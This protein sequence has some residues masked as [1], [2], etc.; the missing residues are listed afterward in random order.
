MKH[1]LYISSFMLLEITIACFPTLNFQ[2]FIQLN[3]NIIW[4]NKGI[5]NQMLI[6]FTNLTLRAYDLNGIPTSTYINLSHQI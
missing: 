1:F 6:Q 5:Q 4:I 2:S 3:N